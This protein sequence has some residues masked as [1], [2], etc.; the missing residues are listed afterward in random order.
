MKI[1][2]RLRVRMMCEGAVMVV[3]AQILGY[4]VLWRMPWGGTV[5]LSMHFLGRDIG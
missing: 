3:A 4:L 1:D 2:P 5:C